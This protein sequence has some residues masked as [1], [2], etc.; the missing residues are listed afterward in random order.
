MKLNFNNYDHT[1]L[2]KFSTVQPG[3]YLCRIFEIKVDSTKNGDPMWKLDM[4]IEDE[5][6][7]KGKHLFDNIVFS[8]RAMA[9]AKHIFIGFGVDV[10]LEREYTPDELQDKY[11]MVSVDRIEK[12]TDREGK[13]REKSSIAYD[14]Y[15]A[16]AETPD[17]IPF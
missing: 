6:E 15:K 10:M 2:Q 11:A 5:C 12:Y 16:V 17:D 13:A 3:T 14:G 8:E 9:R 7:F 1:N 4:V